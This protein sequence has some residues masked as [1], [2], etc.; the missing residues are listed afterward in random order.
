MP[1]EYVCCCFDIVIII[2][3]SKPVGHCGRERSLAET[4]ISGLGVGISFRT[5]WQ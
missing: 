5:L 3:S 1:N 2:G 4:V